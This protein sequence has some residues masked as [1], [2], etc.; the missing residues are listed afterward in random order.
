MVLT[1]SYAATLIV[2]IVALFC[3][4]SWVNTFKLGKGW[5]FEFYYFDFAI[6]VLLATVLI[7]FTV[8]SMGFD[9]FSFGDDMMHGGKRQWMFAFLAGALFNLANMLLIGASSVAGITVAFPM[10]AGIGLVVG[11]LLNLA[12]NGGVNAGLIAGG[13]L[14]L[15]LAVAAD[16]SAYSGLLMIRHEEMAKAGKAKSTRRPKPTKVLLLCLAGGVFM[17]LSPLLTRMAASGELGLGP[18]S[19]SFMFAAGLFFSTIAYNMFFVNL[20]VEGDPAE[21]GEFFKV[22]PKVHLLGLSGG[23]IWAIGAAATLVALAAPPEATLGSAIGYLLPQCF[24]LIAA[25]WGLLLWKEFR[26]ADLRVKMSAV[27]TLVFYLCG[28]ALLSVAPMFVRQG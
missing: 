20:P 17:G 16:A 2:M 14:M 6:G 10:V 15:V 5:R 18:Y 3:L 27:V 23:A 7:V 8:G 9:G 4:G 26:G 28:L 25:L 21:M 12:V 13:C 24:A 19:I 22:S 1:Q 11:S